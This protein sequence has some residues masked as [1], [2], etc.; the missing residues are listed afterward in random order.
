MTAQGAKEAQNR[1]ASLQIDGRSAG[2]RRYPRFPRTDHLLAVDFD[3][4]SAKRSRRRVR[5]D[6]RRDG[7][8]AVQEPS[9][10]DSLFPCGPCRQSDDAQGVGLRQD[11]GFAFDMALRL[12]SGQAT[13]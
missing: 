6:S 13:H 2:W 10:D 12:G 5:N 3:P 1:R 7:L 9:A 4:P 8:L 11:E